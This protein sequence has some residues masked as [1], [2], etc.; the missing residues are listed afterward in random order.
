MKNLAAFSQ[1]LHH[2]TKRFL[3]LCGE[4]VKPLLD[5]LPLQQNRSLVR[6]RI[7]MVMTEAAVDRPSPFGMGN[8]HNWEPREESGNWHRRT[9]LVSST[10]AAR[11]SGAITS[12]SALPIAFVR[13]DRCL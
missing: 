8:R 2:P 12:P 5:E 3:R 10:C 9:R 6:R 11:I 1:R 4:Q 13:L 7:E